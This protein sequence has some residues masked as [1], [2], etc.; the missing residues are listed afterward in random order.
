V[1][2]RLRVWA[3]LYAGPIIANSEPPMC[4]AAY[5]P[6][7]LRTEPPMCRSR[8][9]TQALI[10]GVLMYGAP[11]VPSRSCTELAYVLAAYIDPLRP[12]PLMY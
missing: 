5:V 2:G 3:P 11:Y 9:C 10:C 7:R 12:E 1:L 6:S 4:R 8:L